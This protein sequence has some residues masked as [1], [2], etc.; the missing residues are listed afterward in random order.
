VNAA[1]PD[2]GSAWRTYE[3]GWTAW[4]HVRTVAALGSAV[5]FVLALGAA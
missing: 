5:A 2:A 3:S 1:A 4:N